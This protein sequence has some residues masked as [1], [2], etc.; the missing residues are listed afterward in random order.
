[1]PIY[2]FRHVAAVA[3]IALST[4]A[5]GPAPSVAPTLAPSPTPHSATSQT[6]APVGQS[7]PKFIEFYADW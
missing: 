4:A 1:M 5:C 3:A 6:S 7:K 2:R